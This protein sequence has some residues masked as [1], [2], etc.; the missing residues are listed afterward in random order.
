V[1]WPA[2]ADRAVYGPLIG[3]RIANWRGLVLT[4]RP[5]VTGEADVFDTP[6]A[7]GEFTTGTEL[8]LWRPGLDR[9]HLA[10]RAAWASLWSKPML[11]VIVG[12]GLILAGIREDDGS[13]ATWLCLS[14]GVL[15]LVTG[16]VAAWINYLYF[17]CDHR[18]SRNGVCFLE[19]IRGEYFYRP[20]DFIE[21]GPPTVDVVSRITVAVRDA[22]SNSAAAWLD[23]QHLRDLH[24][25]AWAALTILDRSRALR[26][27]VDQSR[28]HGTYNELVRAGE[29]NLASLDHAVD[30]IRTYLFD[31]VALVHALERKLSDGEQR[32]RLHA[33]LRHFP[34]GAIAAT[35]RAAESTLDGVFAYVTAARDVT[36]TGPFDWELWSREAHYDAVRTP[37]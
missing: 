9:R 23:P 30:A 24:N 13:A 32:A 16:A 27:A 34:R 12:A 6:V 21:L 2:R 1:R 19:R 15:G 7:E 18:H 26:D 35:V 8:M 14:T 33:E 4:G 11:R 17:D 5:S 29:D 37:S 36:H 10:G 25:V 31:A 3:G 28:C 20:S 22:H